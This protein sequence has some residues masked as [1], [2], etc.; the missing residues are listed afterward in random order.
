[1]VCHIIDATTKCPVQTELYESP[2]G[3]PKPD[4]ARPKPWTTKP[5]SSISIRAELKMHDPIHII[6][7]AFVNMVSGGFV[8]TAPWFFGQLASSYLKMY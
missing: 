7:N 1:V 3:L 2:K 6:R 5:S 8:D 4:I